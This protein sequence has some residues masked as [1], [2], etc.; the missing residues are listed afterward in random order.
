MTS[1]SNRLYHLRQFHR[2]TQQEVADALA[3]SRSTYSYYESGKTQ[4]SIQT[5]AKM[6]AFFHVTTDYLILGKIQP[7]YKKRQRL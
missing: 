3:I 7:I 5:V 4:P 6:A 2:M 1:F